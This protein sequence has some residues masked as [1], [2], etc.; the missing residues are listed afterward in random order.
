MYTIENVPE[1]FLKFS[2]TDAG[3]KNILSQE[4]D[5]EIYYTDT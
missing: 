5:G 3:I 4:V 2:F 1:E